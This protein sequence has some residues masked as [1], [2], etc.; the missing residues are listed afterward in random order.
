M[1][2]FRKKYEPGN[3]Q[4]LL[5]EDNDADARLV[6]ET[7]KDSKINSTMHRAEDGEEALDFLGKR[8]KYTK[9]PTPDLVLLDL[10]LPKVNGMEVLK[11]IKTNEATKMIPVVVLSM[12]K[13]E[14]DIEESYRLNANYY[15]SKS[16]NLNEFMEVFEMILITWLNRNKLPANK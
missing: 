5:V 13:S 6:K 9:V 16:L 7:L 10:N 1:K 8:G 15:V 3:I 4:I 2:F 12:S 11:T 14:K